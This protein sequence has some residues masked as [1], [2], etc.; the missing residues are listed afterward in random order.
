MMTKICYI[1]SHQLK[2]NMQEGKKMTFNDD[3]YSLVDPRINFS[4][5]G[6]LWTYLRFHKTPNHSAEQFKMDKTRLYNESYS[7]I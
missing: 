7:G 2:K 1:L 3:T 4:S 5:A 6:N